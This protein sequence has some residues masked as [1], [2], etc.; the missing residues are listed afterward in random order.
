MR[1]ARGGSRAKDVLCFSS[2][3]SGPTDVVPDLAAI[4]P[5]VLRGLVLRS[6][7]LAV[8]D[9]MAS[10][11]ASTPF[12][13]EDHQIHEEPRRVHTAEAGGPV[14][15]H[16]R[17]GEIGREVHTGGRRHLPSFLAVALAGARSGTPCTP[18]TPRTPEV[19]TCVPCRGPRDGS[20][21][22]G[23]SLV[24]LETSGIGELLRWL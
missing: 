23:V 21:R 14:A 11:L 10:F 1:P 18:R 15:S 4:L 9:C 16:H 8:R 6:R 3:L 17:G 20:T 5:T 22:D 2:C 24:R 13:A 7:R 12:L 19:S